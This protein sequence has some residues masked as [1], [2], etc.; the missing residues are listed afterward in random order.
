MSRI[1]SATTGFIATHLGPSPV[2]AG[3]QMVTPFVYA[4]GAPSYIDFLT[5]AF[6]AVEEFRHEAGGNGHAR[7][8]PDRQR[9]DRNGRRP[10]PEESEHTAFYLYVPDVDTL[11]NRAVAAGAASLSAP[12]DQWYGERVAAVKDTMG[13]TWYMARPIR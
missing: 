7:P 5:R 3:F 4:S 8:R 6:G 11:Y 2:P 9:G 1:R 10:G 13:I 12:V